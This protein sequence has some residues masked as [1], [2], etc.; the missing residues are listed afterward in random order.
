MEV[1]KRK[2]EQ[3]LDIIYDLYRDDDGNNTY[4]VTD[5][6]LLS[7]EGWKILLLLKINILLNQ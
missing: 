5:R 6:I 7:N 3:T 2:V 1:K 4:V